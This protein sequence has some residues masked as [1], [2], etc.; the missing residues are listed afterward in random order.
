MRS[1]G[2]WTE[3]AALKLRYD[4]ALDPKGRGNHY[5]WEGGTGFGMR[6]YRS[7]RRTWV[8][9]TTVTISSTGKQTSRFFKLG[10]VLNT[11][12]KTARVAATPKLN[13]MHAGIDPRAVDAESSRVTQQAAEAAT[14]LQTTLLQAIGYYVENRNCAPRSKGDL[15]STL[16]ANLGDWMEKPFL[17]IDT[18]MLQKRY[19]SV[20]AC[21]R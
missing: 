5:I 11:R 3:E 21:K 8:C 10:N 17:E 4:P 13:A 9:A 14:L 19:R 18:N 6:L 1:T 15:Q 20:I 12:L 7:G 16:N 2:R